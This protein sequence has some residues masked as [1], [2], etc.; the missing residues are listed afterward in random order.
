MSSENILHIVLAIIHKEGEVLLIK[1]AIPDELVPELTWAFPGGKVEKGEKGRQFIYDRL[2]TEVDDE[3][4]IEIEIE[5]HIGVRNY[6]TQ[7][8]ILLEYYLCRPKDSEPLVTAQPHEV[9][10]IKWVPAS[11]VPNYLTSDIAPQVLEVLKELEKET[12][13]PNK[14]IIN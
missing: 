8:K 2:K 5:K 4:G 9:A 6:P 12:T 11:E 13:K 10:E 3:V 14:E 1:R 7:P